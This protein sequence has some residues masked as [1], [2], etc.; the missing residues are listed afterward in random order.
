[1]RRAWLLVPVALGPLAGCGGDD[2]ERAIPSAS[3][4][5]SVGPA[6]PGSA[7][8]PPLPTDMEAAADAAGVPVLDDE[9]FETHTHTYLFVVADGQDVPVP[10]GI[11]ID[12]EA[13]RI[14]ALHTHAGDQLLHVESPRA[15]DTYT[16]GQAL[17]MWGI[18]GTDAGVCQ[19]FLGTDDCSVSLED[20]EVTEGTTSLADVDLTAVT[21]GFDHVL[22]DQHAV[23]M[24]VTTDG[25]LG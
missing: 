5:T 23:V 14:A 12:E 22:V 15:D 13:G 1:M 21:D 4:S 7:R 25:E 8:V 19:A 6:A 17:E 20:G 16:V 11:G 9:A 3:A 2:T 24:T 10:A 18:S